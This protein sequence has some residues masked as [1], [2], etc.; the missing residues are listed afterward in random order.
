MERALLFS[1]ALSLALGAG[2]HGKSHG[3][4][5]VPA[6]RPVLFETEPNDGASY[7]EGIGAVRPGTRLAIRGS[8]VQNAVLD[9]YEFDWAADYF[10]GFAFIVAEPCELYLTLWAD[11]P[12]ADLDIWVYDPYAGQFIATFEDIYDPEL[13]AVVFPWIGEE[14]HVVVSSYRR[15]SAYTLELDAFPI[16]G[17]Y[18]ASPAGSAP[19][20]EAAARAEADPRPRPRVIVGAPAESEE[21]PSKAPERL[22]PYADDAPA[23]PVRAIGIGVDP[24]DG[25]VHGVPLE[26]A[27]RG[28]AGSSS[29]SRESVE[30]STSRP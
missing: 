27:P 6:P 7:A 23:R 13:G 11:N 15:D 21:A 12:F 18:L 25:R 4:G 30:E 19:A 1:A 14:F 28:I 10:D 8:V 16:S 9:G 5:P 26:L 17:P 2:C 22:A 24:T 3:H 20:P 29:S